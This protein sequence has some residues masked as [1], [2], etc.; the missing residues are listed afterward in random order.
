MALFPDRYKCLDLL[1]LEKI[2][3]NPQDNTITTNDPDL[4]ADY[5]AVTGWLRGWFSAWNH[6]PGSDGNVTK[7]TKT[8]QIMGWIFSYCR[9]HPSET[10]DLAAIEFMNAVHRDSTTKT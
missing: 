3:V 8:F 6:H 7:G 1:E 5:H 9:A 10:L 2:K 4:A